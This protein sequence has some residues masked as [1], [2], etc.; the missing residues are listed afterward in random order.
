MS[1]DDKVPAYAI[2]CVVAAFIGNMARCMIWSKPEQ[3]WKELIRFLI[4]ICIGVDLEHDPEGQ[5]VHSFHL[6]VGLTMQPKN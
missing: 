6:G 2:R 3:L 5:G 4:S 1:V